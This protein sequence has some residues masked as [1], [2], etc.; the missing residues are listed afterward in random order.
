MWHNEHYI[1][2]L[3]LHKCVIVNVK[4]RE[5]VIQKALKP[6]IGPL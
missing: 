1:I 4:R 5:T 3:T 6:V 2:K